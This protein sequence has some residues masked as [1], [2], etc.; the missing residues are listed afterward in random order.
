M[1][2]LKYKENENSSILLNLSTLFWSLVCNCS[3]GVINS[4]VDTFL[5]HI[6]RELDATQFFFMGDLLD[7]LV[8]KC[9]QRMIPSILDLVFEKLIRDRTKP[10]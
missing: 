10:L 9:P 7:C 3:D 6:E 5:T 1:H 8:Y 2:I 4:V